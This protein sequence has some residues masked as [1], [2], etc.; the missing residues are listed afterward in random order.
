MLRDYLTDLFPILELGTSAKMLSIVPLLAGGGLFETGAGGSAPKHVEQFLK[1]GHL[2]WDSLGE[3][4]AMAVSLEHLADSTSNARAKDL[5]ASLN[6]AIDRILQNRKSPSRKVNEL[7]N[8]ASNFYVTLYWA[9]LM[10]E[11][12]AAFRPLADKLK[13]VRGQVVSE[14]KLA[15]GR[16][17]DIGGY[18]KF[19][20]KKCAVE[21]RPS[22][23]FNK[24]LDG[25]W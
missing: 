6:A 2:R 11:R 23:T 1:E 3:Y 5:A 12:D 16:A 9:E 24:I 14:F 7:D 13:A 8:R 25:E 15:Q 18:Y 17:V 20:D 4:L 10:A 21:L 22:P 19:D